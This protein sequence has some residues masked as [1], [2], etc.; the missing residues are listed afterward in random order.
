MPFEQGFHDVDV[1]AAS[2][3]VQRRVSAPVPG[4]DVDLHSKGWRL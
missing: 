3:Q 4:V 2:S 1:A